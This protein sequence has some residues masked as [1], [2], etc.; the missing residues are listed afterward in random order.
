MA[1]VSAKVFEH[2]LKDDG[3]CNVKIV[4]YHK[5]TRKF[6]DTIHY[7][8]KRQM[9]A[10]FKIKDKFMIRILEDVLEDYRRVISSLEMRMDFF[11]CEDL[12]DY[13]RDKDGDIDFVKF[14]SG[15]IEQLIL[16]KRDGTANNHRAIK[17]SLIDYF[18]KEKISIN[19]IHS[20]MLVSYV[21][22]LKHS[23][24]MIRVN[25]LG[26]N[27]TTIEQVLSDSGLHNYLRDLRTLFNEARR[28]YNNDD[29]GILRNPCIK[30]TFILLQ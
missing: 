10:D 20:N 7:A 5:G 15:H 22:Y 11:S 9:D 17:N 18:K 2:H 25:Q 12:R 30:T 1:T 29:L 21:R 13:L 24:E 3:T 23:R 26:K 16:E 19:E 27:V 8:G 28:H 14:C 4:V 6:I